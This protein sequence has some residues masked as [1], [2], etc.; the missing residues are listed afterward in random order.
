MEHEF[1]ILWFEN[2]VMLLSPLSRNKGTFQL[3]D[4]PQAIL[5]SLDWKEVDLEAKGI[6]Q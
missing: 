3:F 2:L 5:S 6:P 1:C 4:C